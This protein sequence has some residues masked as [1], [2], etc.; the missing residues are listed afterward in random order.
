MIIKHVTNLI[1]IPVV[2]VISICMT[3]SFALAMAIEIQFCRTLDLAKLETSGPGFSSR[4]RTTGVFSC[5]A[6]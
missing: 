6:N 1:A 3:F 4:V 2:V 5:D